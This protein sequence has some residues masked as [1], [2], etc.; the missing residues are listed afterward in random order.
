MEAVVGLK[1]EGEFEQLEGR[2]VN[3]RSNSTDR[4]CA[5]EIIVIEEIDGDRWSVFEAYAE[6]KHFGYVEENT[7]SLWFKDSTH[8]DMKKNLKLFK[9]DADSI[10]MCK[11]AKM[12]DYVE[13]YVVHKVEEEDVFSAAGYIDVGEKDGMDDI[14]EGQELVVYGGVEEGQNQYEPSAADSEEEERDDEVNQEVKYGYSSDSDSLDSEYK[15]SREEDD[16]EDDFHFTDSDDELDPDVSGFQDVNV[17]NKKCRAMKK[18]SV[19]N[20]DFENDEKGNSDDLDLDHEVG[21]EGSD[22]EHQGVRY[23]VHKVQKNMN[24]YKWEVGIVYASRE[25]FKD[26]VTTYAVHTARAIRF[27][28]C[29]LKRVRAVCSGDYPFWL[30]AAKIGDEDTWVG[31]LHTK[32]LGKAFKK[33]V[34]VNPKVKIKELVS[35]AQK[36]WSLIVTKSLARVLEGKSRLFCSHIS[37]EGLLPAYDDVIPGVDNRFCVRHLYSNFRKRFPGLQLKQLMWKCAKATHRKD[38]ERHIAELKAVNQEAF[39]YLNAIPPMYWSR[40]RFTYNSKVDTLVNNMS[41]S[42]N[43]AIVDAREKPIVTILEKIRVKIMTRRAE[44]RELAQNYLG[45]ILPRI[46]IRLERKSRSAK[47]WQPYWSAAQKYE[48]LNWNLFRGLPETSSSVVLVRPEVGVRDPSLICGVV[49]GCTCNDTPMLK[50]WA[51]FLLMGLLSFVGLRSDLRRGPWDEVGPFMDFAEFGGARSGRPSHRPVKKRR[52]AVGD[53]K[54]SSCTHLLR[55]E[56][57]QRCSICGSVGRN[58]SRCLEPIEDLPP[59]AKGGRKTTFSQPIP[60]LA[61]N[62]EAASATQPPFSAQSNNAAQPKRP[63]GRSKGTTKPNC[64]TQHDPQPKKLASPTSF[65]PPSSSSQPTTRT[66]PSSQLTLVTSSS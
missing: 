60:K 31:I 5:G 9:G 33:K 18:N 19:A 45:I 8:K 51:A 2:D 64:S 44:N 43:S 34:K 40:S 27:R 37:A 41:E 32:W 42:F 6:L 56:E 20:E 58:K 10:A 48:G 12:R 65:A 30:Y 55:K 57:K 61:V 39:Q 22:S 25:E 36:K 26:T 16:S 59:A 4:V 11:I 13:L 1:R 46:R 14:S 52:P 15:P 28:K 7:P 62:R 3:S 17:M 49:G 47:E 29:D 54:Q 66:L 63:R 50:F 38:W 24:Q 53:E 21:A 23:P 35:R